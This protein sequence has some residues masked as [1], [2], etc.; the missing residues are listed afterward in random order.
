MSL[1]QALT[2]CDASCT[3]EL[4]RAYKHFQSEKYFDR[5]LVECL[6]QPKT[7]KAASWL[8]KHYLE[9]GFILDEL[10]VRKTLLTLLQTQ[11][12]D[13]RLHL[14]Q[15]LGMLNI[16]TELAHQLFQK[17]KLLTADKNKMVR[18][19]AYNGLH[20]VAKQFPHY[21]TQTWEILSA[22]AENEAPSVQARIRKITRLDYYSLQK[23]CG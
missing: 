2:L 13:T 20:E 21:K 9:E 22:V 8:L 16:E 1:Q 4:L 12:W 5:R 11:L 15:C 23:D 18:A 3:D 6:R 10:L 7:E 19:W 14:L 17:L